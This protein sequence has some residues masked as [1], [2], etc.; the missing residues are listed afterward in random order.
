MNQ[1]T[2]KSSAPNKMSSPIAKT[3]LLFTTVL[4]VIVLSMVFIVGHHDDLDNRVQFSLTDH[5]GNTVN[6]KNFAGRHQLVFFGFTSCKMI[7]PTQMQKLTQVIHTLEQNGDGHKVNPLFITVDPERDNSEKIDAYLKHFHERI[8]GLTGS[9]EALS[10]AAESFKTL[11]ADAPSKPE[12]GYQIS[13][14][15]MVYVVDPFS[16]VVDYLSFDTGI[17]GMV[18]KLESLL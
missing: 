8:T 1:P 10:S 13:H 3:A 6:E 5:A 12:P 17:D 11:L 18:E 15:S 14:S 7:C 16:R 4:G 2:S 9:R